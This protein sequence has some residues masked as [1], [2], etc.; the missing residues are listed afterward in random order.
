[1]SI[2]VCQEEYRQRS[3]SNLPVWTAVASQ[4]NG[5]ATR[6]IKIDRAFTAISGKISSTGSCLRLESTPAR[7]ASQ[8]AKVTA[9][10]DILGWLVGKQLLLNCF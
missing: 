4:S 8:A 10:N 1:M 6:S 5:S 7:T 9:A 3:S 2:S